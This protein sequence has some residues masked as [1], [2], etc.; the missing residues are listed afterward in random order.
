MERDTGKSR[1]LCPFIQSPP[2]N[3]CHCIKHVT[4]SLSIEPAI[5]YCCENF[6]EC[7][8]YKKTLLETL[9]VVG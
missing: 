4:D 5:Y 1:R 3:S 6:L 7:E 2:S 8:I 9:K